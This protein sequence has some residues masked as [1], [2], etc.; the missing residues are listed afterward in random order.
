MLS[1]DTAK[2]SAIRRVKSSRGIR[3]WCFGVGARCCLG[4]RG[5]RPAVAVPGEARQIHVEGQ[6]IPVEKSP[7]VYRV[8]GGLVGTYRLRSERVIYAW[9]YFGTQI[10][11]IEGIESINGCVDQNQNESCD[12]GEPSSEPTRSSAVAGSAVES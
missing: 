5:G 8:T 11:D 4:R 12:A 7:G 3:I 6:L 10:R 9:T 2:Q 1:R